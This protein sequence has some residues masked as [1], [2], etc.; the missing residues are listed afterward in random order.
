MPEGACQTADRVSYTNLVPYTDQTINQFSRAADC[1]GLW[2]C[3]GCTSGLREIFHNHLCSRDQGY[4]MALMARGDRSSWPAV[5]V[6]V[7]LKHPIRLGR[8]YRTSIRQQLKVP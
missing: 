3:V 2:Q 4:L 8:I 7:L 5:R 1:C 6:M